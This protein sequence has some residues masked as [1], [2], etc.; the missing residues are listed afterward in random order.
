MSAPEAITRLGALGY[1]HEGK[2]YLA[3]PEARPTRLTPAGPC[4]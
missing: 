2:R 3:L 1:Q 4:P